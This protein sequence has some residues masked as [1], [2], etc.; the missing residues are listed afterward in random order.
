MISSE[1]E[2][3]R[4]LILAFV[5]EVLEGTSTFLTLMFWHWCFKR[6]NLNILF[7]V[8][9]KSQQRKIFPNRSCT[10]NYGK[11]LRIEHK[12]VILKDV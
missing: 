1:A 6:I 2:E 9:Q 11:M 4:I 8:S 10:E 5:M 7:V 3:A 12:D